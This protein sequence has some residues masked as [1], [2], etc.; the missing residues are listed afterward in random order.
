M[1]RRNSKHVHLVSREALD[2]E[3]AEVLDLVDSDMRA[4]L[5]WECKIIENYE[6]IRSIILD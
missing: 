6:A 1:T 3:V 4:E 5:K 2:T